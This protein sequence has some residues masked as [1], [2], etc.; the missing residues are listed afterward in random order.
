MVLLLLLF[1][2]NDLVRMARNLGRFI[3]RVTRSDNY[4]AIQQASRE[5]RTLPERL[6]R[7]AQLEEHREARKAPEPPKPAAPAPASPSDQPYQA[8]T[9]ELPSPP[10]APGEDRPPE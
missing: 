2:P 5:L 3:N 4:Q 1:G 6:V 10:A 8:W 7:E 9:Q